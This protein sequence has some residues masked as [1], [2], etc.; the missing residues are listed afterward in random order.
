VKTT[1]CLPGDLGVP[2]LSRWREI[3]SGTRDLDSP[4]L[5]PEFA[6]AVGRAKPNARVAVLEEAGR[7]IAFFPFERRPFGLGVPIGAGLSDSQAIICEPELQID[8]HEMLARCGL[9]AWR[10]DCLVA[11]QR[12]LMAPTA[13]ECNSPIIEFSGGFDKYMTGKGRHSR[14]TLQ[15]ERKLAREVGPV[16]FGF[17]VSD[18]EAL[19]RMLAWKSEQYKRTGRPDRFADKSTVQ[20]ICELAKMSEPDLSGTLMTL[21]AGDRLVAV[22]FSLRSR[23]TLAGWFPAHDCEFS[24]YS[25]GSIRTL[26]TIEAAC[27]AGLQRYDFG[28]GDEVYKGWIKTGDLQVCEGWVVRPVILGYLRRA[29]GMPR[30]IALRVVLGHPRLRRFARTAL[31]RIGSTRLFLERGGRT[32]AAR[33]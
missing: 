29:T 27:L 23:T 19:H 2:E 25:P 13:L 11:T 1:V 14:T 33:A 3:R 16:R 8:V 10:F 22:E 30:E 18:D 6:Q 20:L 28:K 5:A 21:H 12:E 24:H 9:S 17:G 15:K 4:F 32:P 31:Q 7:I 26:R